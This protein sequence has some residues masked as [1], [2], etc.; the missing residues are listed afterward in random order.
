MIRFA[1]ALGLVAAA[2]TGTT[3]DES[4][5]DTGTDPA[6]PPVE[7]PSDLAPGT[8]D[9]RTMTMSDG[10]ELTYVLILP[11]GFDPS[12]E[13]PVLLALPPGDQGLGLTTALAESTF[14]PEAFRR[15]WVVISPVA[16]DGVL[17][18]QGSERFIGELLE[19][20][21]WIRSEGDRVH[22]AGISNGGISTF[23]VAALMPDRVTSL[24]VFPG[25]PVSDE[26]RAA[27]DQLSALPIAMWVGGND[28]AW[29]DR[30]TEARDLLS[31]LGADVQ[32][33]VREGEGHVMP[34][35]A[36]GVDLYDFLE[37]ARTQG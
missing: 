35:M 9:L 23:R 29:L 7:V 13:Y 37:T 12:S 33:D 27:L 2:C 24:A 32:F 16:P 30:M 19:A 1:V 17:F 14:G 31:S 4:A 21:A 10:T 34:S 8:I 22:V 18:F 5:S 6:P 11:E 20:H 28:P 25:Y 15:G 36:D 26:D 3:A